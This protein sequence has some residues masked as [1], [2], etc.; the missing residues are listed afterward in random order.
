MTS[1]VTSLLSISAW[2]L[3]MSHESS[4]CLCLE[5]HEVGHKPDNWKYKGSVL[6]QNMSC[7]VT[8]NTLR[9]LKHQG[10]KP[11]LP[12]CCCPWAVASALLMIQAPSLAP[13]EMPALF[14]RNK[15]IILC[16]REQPL[17]FY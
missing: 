12:F 6:A 16:M 2:G 17:A 1:C 4:V 13:K 3:R 15:E 5:M 9:V 11:Q 14:L 8:V 10:L 7:E